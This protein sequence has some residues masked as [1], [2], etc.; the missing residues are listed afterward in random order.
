ML[1]APGL[2]YRS[3]QRLN[4]TGMISSFGCTCYGR[5]CRQSFEY[6]DNSHDKRLQRKVCA[7]CPFDDLQSSYQ[8]SLS[9]R[10]LLHLS[11]AMPS[12]KP[13]EVVVD[14]CKFSSDSSS[15]EVLLVTVLVLLLIAIVIIL[16]K[17]IYQSFTSCLYKAQALALCRPLISPP[18]QNSL[19]LDNV[20]T[21]HALQHGC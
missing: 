6:L 9:Q 15:K 18:S 12:A 14:L 19:V 21:V 17:P 5:L 13:C 16:L 7:I 1:H 3:K 8:N 10:T 11:S 20:C 2:N 4:R